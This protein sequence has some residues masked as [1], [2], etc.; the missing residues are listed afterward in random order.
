MLLVSQIADSRWLGI[1]AQLAEAESLVRAVF[2]GSM[3][4]SSL[5]H[6]TLRG[7]PGSLL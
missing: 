2:S 1:I 3:L 4:V 5:R 7:S 6:V